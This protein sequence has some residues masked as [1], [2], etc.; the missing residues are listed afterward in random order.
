[1]FR[2]LNPGEVLRPPTDLGEI[3]AGLYMVKAVGC[4]IEIATVKIIGDS[5]GDCGTDTGVDLKGVR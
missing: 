3:L 1:M 5:G 2:Y 4:L